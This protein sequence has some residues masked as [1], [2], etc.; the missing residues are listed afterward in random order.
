M[1]KGGSALN[2]SSAFGVTLPGLAAD[3]GGERERVQWVGY[4]FIAA[5]A[6]EIDN[7]TNDPRTLWPR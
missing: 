4:L 3:V 5:F 2:V 7:G 1:P 6:S